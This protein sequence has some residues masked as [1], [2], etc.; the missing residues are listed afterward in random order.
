MPDIISSLKNKLDRENENETCGLILNDDT[1]VD[2]DNI[3]SEPTKGFRMSVKDIAKHES[4]MIGTWHTHPHDTA[5]LSQEDYLGFKQW[6]KLIHYIVG[7]D[8]VRAFEVVGELIIE[9]T[10]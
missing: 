6:P 8:G 4:K 1:I 10:K 7:V 3:H 9:V 2:I 5:N